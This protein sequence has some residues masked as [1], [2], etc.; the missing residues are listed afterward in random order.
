MVRLTTDNYGWTVLWILE[1]VGE[2]RLGQVNLNAL[3][4]SQCAGSYSYTLTTIPA[5]SHTTL[6]NITIG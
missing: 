4:T 3:L 6:L 2:Q 5:S 1:S